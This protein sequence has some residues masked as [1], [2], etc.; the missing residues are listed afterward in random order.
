VAK[1]VL[2]PA[3]LTSQHYTDDTSIKAKG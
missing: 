1:T 3:N 2:A